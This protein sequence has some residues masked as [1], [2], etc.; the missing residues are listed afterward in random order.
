MSI[1][2]VIL[3]REP[4]GFGGMEK[5][6]VLWS[7]TTDRANPVRLIAIYSADGGYVGNE[8]CAA[9]LAARGIV[10]ERAPGLTVATIGFCAQDQQWYGWSHR[11][12]C[13]FGIGDRVKDGDCTAR[14]AWSDDYLLA[15][16]ED[17]L[18]LPI[19]FV[20]RTLDD[21]RRMA[22]A[23]AAAVG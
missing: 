5:R 16:P 15:H 18:A 20:A 8:G 21:A 4:F 1:H 22:I 9:F 3:H 7:A 17:D 2:E 12:Y 6:D 19:G 10:P 14:A 23:F 13:G 11:A